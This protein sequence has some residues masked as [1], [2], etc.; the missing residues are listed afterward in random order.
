MRNL[1]SRTVVLGLILIMG[2]FGGNL[3]TASPLDV[4]GHYFS[5]RLD[6][7]VLKMPSAV[8]SVGAQQLDHTTNVFDNQLVSP[9][10]FAPASGTEAWIAWTDV[11]N[12]GHVSML[13][14]GMELKG[15]ECV[16]EKQTVRDLI[17]VPDNRVLVASLAGAK[18]KISEFQSNADGC[19]PARSWTLPRNSL[20]IHP[21]ALSANQKSYWIMA[22][23]QIMRHE[24]SGLWKIDEKGNLDEVTGL[25]PTPKSIPLTFV[26]LSIACDRFD[27]IMNGG[28]YPHMGISDKAGVSLVF[29]RG[30]N[31]GHV[32]L[33]LGDAQVVN[34]RRVMV[35]T[36]YNEKPAIKAAIVGHDYGR[37]VT[38]L[39][40]VDDS[41]AKKPALKS[42]FKKGDRTRVDITV[43]TTDQLPAKAHLGSFDDR[44]FF[45]VWE[46]RRSNRTFA[47]SFALNGNAL[48]E[49]E[50]ID[51]RLAAHGRIRY[52]KNGDA[53]WATVDK[54]DNKLVRIH[55]LKKNAK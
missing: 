22:G 54:D 18:F 21:I 32:F 39:S 6:K 8:A 41:D 3:L 33:A 37:D 24:V 36:D 9:I 14:E 11:E 26:G 23:Y 15:K 27:F 52:L 51:A 30:T 2:S 46:D 19:V 45:V 5:S 40:V 35:Y 17:R 49:P 55:L 34:D 28:P 43:S 4:D 44:S 47:Q 31:T 42:E 13:S 16:L 25:S 10:L 29:G 12:N 48:T 53:I 38:V 7:K 50:E 1:W 20:P